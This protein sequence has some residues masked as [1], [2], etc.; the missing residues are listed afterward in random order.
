MKALVIGGTRNLG[1]PLVS[2]L[3]DRGFEVTVFHRG[4]TQA[5]LPPSVERIYGDRSDAAQL[6]AGVGGRDFDVV[7]DTTLYNGADAQSA[8]RIFHSRTGR[9]IML[10]TGQVYL[11]RSGLSR[12]FQET[13]YLGPT[14]PAPARAADLEDWRYGIDKRAA[15]DALL[16]AHQAHG[17]PVTVLRLPMVN[18]ERDHHHRLDGYLGRLG[19]GGPILIPDGPHLTLRHVYG[20]DVV[21]AMVSLSESSSGHGQAYNLSQDEELTID[22]FLGTLARIAGAELR[23]VKVP[24]Q[25]LEAENLLP[26]CSPFSGLWMSNLDNARSKSEL[27]INYTPLEIY[28][29]KLVAHFS[30]RPCH[31]PGYQRRR[32]ELSIAREFDAQR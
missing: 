1:P 24:R 4:Q 5:P 2:S 23:T 17:F 6:E 25:R 28:L 12:P 3:I 15:E 27:G 14:I 13:D 18:S 21:R 32:L 30:S 11:V 19:D 8:A 7:I 31:Q 10:S 29:S 26:A 9:Y 20:G 16:T 22:E